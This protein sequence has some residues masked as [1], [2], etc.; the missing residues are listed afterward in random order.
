MKSIRS[1]GLLQPIIVRSVRE[2]LEIVA[3]ER[4]FEACRRL[5]WRNV[6]CVVHNLSDKES[7]EVALSENIERETLNPIEEAIAF[8][9]YVREFG[10]GGESEL[11]K[12]IGKSQQY[13]SQRLQLLDLP[14]PVLDLVTRRQ[15]NPSVATELIW[16][17]DS[18]AQNQIAQMASLLKLSQ[19]EVRDLVRSIR[20]AVVVDNRSLSEENTTRADIVQ[21]RKS[22]VSTLTVVNPSDTSFPIAVSVKL[23]EPKDRRAVDRALLSLKIALFRID[24]ILNEGV[25]DQALRELI[26]RT[27]VQLHDMADP[28]IKFKMKNRWNSTNY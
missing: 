26:L 7:F 18:V 1:V 25:E 11:A 4:R 14:K 6:P 28:L 21:S 10:W 20:K 13:V 22:P 19:R 16:A 3:G 15:V 17:K 27:R 24:S 9:R 5:R 12:R 8:K 2:S 23:K